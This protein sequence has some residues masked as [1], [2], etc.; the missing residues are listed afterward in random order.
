MIFAYSHTE[1]SDCLSYFASEA[2]LSVGG[3]YE[4]AFEIKG[5]LCLYY[6]VKAPTDCALIVWDRKFIRTDLVRIPQMG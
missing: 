5:W 2:K 4:Q 1:C 3:Q 6:Q